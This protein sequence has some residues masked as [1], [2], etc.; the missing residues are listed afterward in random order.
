MNTYIYEPIVNE[1]QEF[2]EIA[3]DFA[4][5]LD[6]VREAISNSYDAKCSNIYLDFSVVQEYGESTFKISIEDDGA[7]MNENQ[8]KAFFDLGNS[9]RKNDKSCIG[10]KGHGTKVYFNSKKIIVTSHQNNRK[11]VGQVENP[12]YEL[13]S[14]KKPKISISLSDEIHSDGTKI[15]ILGYNSNRRDKFTHDNLRDYI[16]WF[17]KHG[18]IDILYEKCPYKS[19]KLHLK[20]LDRNEEA[21]TIEYGHIFPKES[22]TLEELLTTYDAKAPD[23]YCKRIKKAV[24]LKNHPEIKIQVI[25]S[26]EGK[27]LKYNYNNM[28]RRPGYTAPSGSY[29][30]Q[31][32][33]GLWL[34]KDFIPI[35]KKNEWVTL[36]GQEFTRFQAFIN[37]QEF[38]LTANRGSVENTPSELMLDIEDSCKM[39][40]KEIIES[41]D[42][43][44]IDWLEG[45]VVASQT[46]EKEKKNFK[47]R[48]DKIKKAN[49]AKY[50]NIILIKPNRESGVYSLFLILSTL[51]KD[52]FPFSIIDYDTHEGIDVIVKGD[53]TT[54]LSSAR[55]FYVEFKYS[56]ENNFNHAFENLHSIICWDTKIKHDE[57]V[58]DLN[59]E[60]RR[61]VIIQPGNGIQYT[62]YWLENQRKQHRI[63]IYVLKDFL[64]QKLNIDFRPRHSDDTV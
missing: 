17:T 38:K 59:K 55:T 28:L 29:T 63:Q 3:N 61:M 14:G 30:M 35:Q 33:Y 16:L 26:I 31:E 21:E 54:P 15:E 4:N 37:C 50:E 22:V 5:P 56:L 40:F 58:T 18:S 24:C 48:L 43:S 52:L 7:G 8:M 44:N 6:I 47:W 49:I 13:H 27:Y 25:F 20:G 46:I 39:I 34:C 41:D 1:T 64:K 53:S 32:R 45:E 9:T 36:K 51:K 12:Y 60:S 2:I 11:I 42:W 62:T 10:E 57:E 19:I 23:Y